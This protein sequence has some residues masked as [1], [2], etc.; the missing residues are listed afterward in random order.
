M[1]PLPGGVK[2]GPGAKE[3]GVK[4]EEGLE[5]AN[6]HFDDETDDDIELSEEEKKAIFH[7]KNKMVKTSDMKVK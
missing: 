5:G 4:E 3:P 6:I 7:Y 2:P 1:E